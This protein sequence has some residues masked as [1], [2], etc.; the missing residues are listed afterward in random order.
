[1][2][3]TSVTEIQNAALIK[4][5]AEVINSEDDDS[6]RARL[7]KVSYPLMR[8]LVLRSHPWK[9]ARGR[10]AL[11]PLDPKPDNFW[12]FR[13]VYQLPADCLRIIETNLGEFAHWDTEDTY[14]LCNESTATIKYIRQITNVTKY[15]A[16]FV[17]VLAWFIAADIAYALAQNVSLKQAME[18]GR[19]KALAPARSFN[20]QQ[21][22]PPRVAADGLNVVRRY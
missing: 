6:K 14:F 8:D 4:L 5:G 20:A 9:F 22:S 10:A 3:V 2:G 1:M 13:Y 15:E 12:E 16:N 11:S 17:E 19:D 18:M 7:V 21:G